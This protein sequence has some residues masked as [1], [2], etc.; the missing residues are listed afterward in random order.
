MA[1]GATNPF[2]ASLVFVFVGLFVGGILSGQV[3]GRFAVQDRKRPPDAW[4]VCAGYSPSW[5][6]SIM[7]YGARMARG[8]TSGQA[9]PAARC[10]RSAVGYSCSPS[11]P[12]A[13]L[14]VRKLWN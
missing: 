14:F 6:G 8:C 2:D 3:F 11:S 13:T 10:C 4:R 12:E 5:A 1:G 9:C 7:G